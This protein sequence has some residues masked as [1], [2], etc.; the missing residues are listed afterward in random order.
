MFSRVIRMLRASTF[1]LVL[2]AAASMSS[3]L[4]ACGAIH[5]GAHYVHQA[6]KAQAPA[7][8]MLGIEQARPF[9][10]ALG[11]LPSGAEILSILAAMS[12]L[13]YGLT[14]Q[15]KSAKALAAHQKALLEV[16]GKLTDTKS[17]SPATTSLVAKSQAGA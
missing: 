6:T 13:V 14:T 12:G 11:G 10:Q 2:A 1:W 17:L 15:K 9:V 16:A 3:L 7:Q 8:P 4:V 5:T